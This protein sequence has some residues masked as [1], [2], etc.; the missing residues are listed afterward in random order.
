MTGMLNVEDEVELGLN[1]A[2]VY[3]SGDLRFTL[4]ATLMVRNSRNLRT[5]PK[6]G[7]VPLVERPF[8]SA[9][10]TTRAKGKRIQPRYLWLY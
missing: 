6:N 8:L 9:R 7:L 4:D 3:P 5:L 2:T 1:A 10:H